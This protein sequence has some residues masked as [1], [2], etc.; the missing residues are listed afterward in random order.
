MCG[1][2]H[3]VAPGAE[4]C[5]YL[6]A[7]KHRLN[8]CI[9]KGSHYLFDQLCFCNAPSPWRLYCFLCICISVESESRS[10][11]EKKQ[12]KKLT[13]ALKMQSECREKQMSEHRTKMTCERR[14]L[15]AAGEWSRWC[16]WCFKWPRYHSCI[17]HTA[18][19]S[20]LSPKPHSVQSAYPWI[21]L[22]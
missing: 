16:Q 7:I 6:N 22:N 5:I 14:G 15:G 9:K 4:E 13:R 21:A 17:K 3:L 18:L 8:Y 12:Q 20:A 11:V 10:G 1:C 2:L 19:Q